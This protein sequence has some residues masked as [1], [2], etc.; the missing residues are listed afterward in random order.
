[1]VGR[2]GPRRPVTAA[3]TSAHVRKSGA[4]VRATVNGP[5]LVEDD[6]TGAVRAPLVTGVTPPRPRGGDFKAIK[7]AGGGASSSTAAARALA[8][9]WLKTGPS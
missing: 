8:L 6:D 7:G 4:R 3:L 9:A 1:M 5:H 2:A